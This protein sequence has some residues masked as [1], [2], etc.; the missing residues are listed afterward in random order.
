[1]RI[2]SLL[3]NDKVIDDKLDNF[4][5]SRIVEYFLDIR[6]LRKDIILF[7]QEY[8]YFV[9]ILLEKLILHIKK[10]TF[11][12]GDSQTVWWSGWDSGMIFDE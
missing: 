7:S 8:F 4:R 2:V 1:M 3:I 5:I 6:I 11:T 10:Q 9:E 12:D